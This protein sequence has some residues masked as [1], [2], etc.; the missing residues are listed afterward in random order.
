[1]DKRASLKWS[2][3]ELL[4]RDHQDVNTKPEFL[5]TFCQ[6]EKMQQLSLTE[7]ILLRLATALHRKHVVVDFFN[8]YG[9]PG[10]R[11][12]EFSV[13]QVADLAGRWYRLDDDSEFAIL[14]SQTAWRP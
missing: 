5:K 4:N 1:M 8:E 14:E 2:R 12:V 10:I 11:D 9:T 3:I 7:D 13:S 6:S